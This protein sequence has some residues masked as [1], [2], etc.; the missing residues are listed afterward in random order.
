VITIFSPS[1][2]RKTTTEVA[3]E[4]RSVIRLQI[5]DRGR[6][7]AREEI[8]GT[9]A[10]PPARSLETKAK[11]QKPPTPKADHPWAAGLAQDAPSDPAGF[12]F[13]HS[14]GGYRRFTKIEHSLFYEKGT[15]LSTNSH[16]TY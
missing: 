8:P 9:V 10:V 5:R 2:V 3:L 16:A 1:C 15:F 4:F 11:K 14:P 13:P 12:H 7:V 6:A